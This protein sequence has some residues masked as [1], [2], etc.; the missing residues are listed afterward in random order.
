[1]KLLDHLIGAIVVLLVSI[2]C[3]GCGLP[4]MSRWR[5]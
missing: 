4:P 5:V 3:I 1:M 2:A